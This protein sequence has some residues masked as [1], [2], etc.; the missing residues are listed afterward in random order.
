MMDRELKLIAAK[1][2]QA[3]YKKNTDLG[4]MEYTF[5][6]TEYHG[7]PL[8]VLAMPGSNEFIDWLW[9]FLLISKNGVKRCTH[10]AADKVYVAIKDQLDPNI[11]LLVTGHSKSGPDALQYKNKYGADHCIAF[12]PPPAFRK[13]TKPTL[14]NTLI[15]I[16][17]DDIVPKLGELSF[18]QPICDVEKLPDDKAWYDLSRI[19]SQHVIDHLV[20]YYSV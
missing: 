17:P 2:C 9:N 3:A 4:S 19:Y 5:T 7:K 18:D 10:L 6:M 1:A 8:Q 15:V 11:P 20:E 14:E 16:D 13:K 12:C